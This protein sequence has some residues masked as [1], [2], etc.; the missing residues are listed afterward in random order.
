M[1]ILHIATDDSALDSA[2][3]VIG[4][5]QA[6]G[7]SQ[8]LIAPRGTALADTAKKTGIAAYTAPRALPFSWL[9]RWRIA[10]QI[11]HHEPQIIQCWTRGAAAMVPYDMQKRLPVVGW[12]AG[13][14]HPFYYR[15]CGHV[16]GATQTVADFEILQGM[17]PACV[18]VIPP[19]PDVSSLP[20]ADRGG[21]TT[22]RSAKVLLCLSRLHPDKGQE[23]LLT[24]MAQRPD[25]WLWLAGEGPSRRD[26]EAKATAL[27]V[28]ERVRFLGNRCD[29]AALLRAA[30][31]CVLPGRREITGEAIVE[32]W[33]AGAP[34]IAAAND[35]AAHLIEEDATGL[36]V[37]TDDAEAMGRAIDTLLTDGELRR[38]LV[39]QS[40]AAYI[41]DYTREA[42][43]R[44]WLSLFE[45]ILTKGPLC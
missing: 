33:A 13:M 8:S 41:K 15:N 14:D 6:A 25:L 40:Y 39:A 7:V 35:A 10:R 11:K 22:P 29:H 38:R 23:L 32:A 19:C 43:T 28:L 18:H 26:L 5:L 12:V 44:R 2:R 9:R 17:T 45:T 36:I 31:I 37:P 20:A 3:R 21:F 34:V 30:D 16:V 42:V 27:G 4:L 24:C 1:K